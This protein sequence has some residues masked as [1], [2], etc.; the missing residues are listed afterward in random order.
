MPGCG[1]RCVLS[2]WRLIDNQLTEH[3]DDYIA[4]FAMMNVDT[5]KI[6][7]LTL[8][9]KKTGPASDLIGACRATAQILASAADADAILPETQSM[10]KLN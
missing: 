1:I 2:T 8:L 7:I 3:E 4:T 10:E 5:D 6:V 9:Q